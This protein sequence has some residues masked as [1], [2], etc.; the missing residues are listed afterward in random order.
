MSVAPHETYEKEYLDHDEISS[1]FPLPDLHFHI[2]QTHLL[3]A[4]REEEEENSDELSTQN[5]SF[6][7]WKC[8]G[9]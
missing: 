9:E 7:F 4:C 1:I 8:H 6:G 5:L 2:T 3:G